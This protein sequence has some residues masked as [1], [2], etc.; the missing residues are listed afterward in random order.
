M[1]STLF[2]LSNSSYTLDDPEFNRI[3]GL[4]D[5]A[6]DMFSGFFLSDLHPIFRYVPTRAASRI[7]KVVDEIFDFINGYIAEHKKTFDESKSHFLQLFNFYKR[8]R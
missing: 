8:T 3:R 4:I 2:S 6:N 1:F 7:R 5:E